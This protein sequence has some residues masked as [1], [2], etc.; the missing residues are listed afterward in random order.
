MLKAHAHVPRPEFY[1]HSLRSIASF[2]SLRP[3]CPSALAVVSLRALTPSVLLASTPL[4]SRLAALQSISSPL[5]PAPVTLPCHC[6]HRRDIF[7]HI[8]WSLV[9]VRN[10]HSPPIYPHF[11]TPW[12]VLTRV[13]CRSA[14]T[15]VQY[16]NHKYLP[17]RKHVL[18][19]KYT[20]LKYEHALSLSFSVG[21]P[22]HANQCSQALSQ[23][24]LNS[25][26]IMSS[27]R[28]MTQRHRN[29]ITISIRCSVSP[30]HTTPSHLQSPSSKF[31][32]RLHPFCPAQRF[33]AAF[34]SRKC[35]EYIDLPNP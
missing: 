11:H 24:F 12:H 9:K 18:L 6:L 33:L 25:T 7:W 23:V 10:A 26:L 8:S 21:N 31:R 2:S 3:L 34:V 4:R 1:Y 15:S 17:F 13:R 30:F 35:S 28:R 14:F 29:T 5:P 16:Y 19:Y 22:C 27:P 32:H 20:T